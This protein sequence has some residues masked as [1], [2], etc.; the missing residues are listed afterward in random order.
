[1]ALV[2]RTTRRRS[3]KWWLAAGLIVTLLV[4]FVDASLKSRSPAPARTMAA[5]AWVDRVMP[6]IGQSTEQGIELNQIRKSGLSMTGSSIESQ[7]RQVAAAARS[8]L[9]AVKGLDPPANMQAASGLLI[10]C[11]Q[12]R[13]A[14]AQNFAQ[15]MSQVLSGPV[16]AAPTQAPA[17]LAAVQ[18]FQVADQAYQLFVQDMPHVGVSLPT[19]VWYSNPTGFSQPSL[20]TYLQS[21]RA[22]TNAVP[23]H[24]VA[25]VAVAT[26]PPAVTS[27]HAV[28]VLPAAAF[29]QIDVTVADVG[30]R[31]ESN[32]PVTASFSPGAPG[33]LSSARQLVD[34]TPGQDLALTVGTLKAPANVAVTLTVSVGPVAG[35]KNTS[36]NTKTLVFKMT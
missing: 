26:N 18:Q 10:A 23:L 34:L 13:A 6:V 27:A 2:S 19:S 20:A 16:V 11:L 25:V 31:P 5:Q 21:L 30:N 15:A 36:D 33:Y 17:V 35:E 3:A 28:Q 22:T 9:D 14:A 32:V 12:T 7:L 4:L 29:V 8:S 1:M 24:D